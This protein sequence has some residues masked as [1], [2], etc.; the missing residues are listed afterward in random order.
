VLLVEEVKGRDTAMRETR[1]RRERFPTGKTFA[2][3]TAVWL[4]ETLGSLSSPNA[5]G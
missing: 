4:D 1:R 5:F 2:C 3:W